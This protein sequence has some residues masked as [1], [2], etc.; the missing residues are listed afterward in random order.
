VK[1]QRDL[2]ENAEEQLQLK[3]TVQDAESAWADEVRAREAAEAAQTD[4]KKTA[5]QVR[6]EARVAPTRTL[7]RLIAAFQKLEASKSAADVLN[8]IVDGLSAEFPRVALLEVRDDHLEA[9]EQR[10]FGGTRLP[11]IDVLASENSAVGDALLTRLVQ[12]RSGQEATA[13]ASRQIFGGSP[14]FLLAL[15]VSVHGEVLAVIYVDDFG[16]DADVDVVVAQRRVKYAQLVL[17]HAVPRLPRFVKARQTT[18][19]C[20]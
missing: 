5:A 20:A 12:S 11:K 4:L 2:E 18:E 3:A 15:P 10:G 14:S 7:D 1:A 9:N 6:Q 16:Q 17:W 13:D 8:A 19:L